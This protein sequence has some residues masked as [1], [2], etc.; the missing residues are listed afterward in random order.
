MRRKGKRKER[1]MTT[2]TRSQLGRLSATIIIGCVIL[3]PALF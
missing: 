2:I 1:A 3:L